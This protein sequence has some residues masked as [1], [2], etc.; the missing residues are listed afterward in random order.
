MAIYIRNTGYPE[1]I[2][3]EQD[4]AEWMK[5]HV[6]V[7]RDDLARIKALAERLGFYEELK[8]LDVQVHDLTPGTDDY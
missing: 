4:A 6:V 2:V 8:A 1:G 3:T 5:V 7:S